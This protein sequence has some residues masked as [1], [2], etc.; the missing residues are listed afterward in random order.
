[1]SIAKTIERIRRELPYANP[2]SLFPNKRN[3]CRVLEAKPWDRDSVEQN[4]GF[5]IPLELCELWNNCGGLILYEDDTYGQWGLAVFPPSNDAVFPPSNS[6]FYN[7]NH[8][9]QNDWRDSMLPG[10]L[11]IGRF[12]GD[13]D[14]PMIRCDKHAPDYN[15][16]YIVADID[17]RPEWCRAASSLEDFLNRFMDAK[18]AKYW[19]NY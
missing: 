10:D 6:T 14:R 11:I 3:V 13:R 8:E 12:W 17:P 16:V 2:N 9:Y 18:G 5:E 19:D 4:L 15:N 1:M 7:L